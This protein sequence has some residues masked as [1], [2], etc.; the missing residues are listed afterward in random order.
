MRKDITDI[1]PVIKVP[2][3]FFLFLAI[4]LTTSLSYITV[5]YQKEQDLKKI[6][7]SIDSL[8]QGKQEVSDYKL[9]N[10]V[11]HLDKI[12]IE[13]DYLNLSTLKVVAG[14]KVLAT[15]PGYRDNYTD[16]IDFNSKLQNFLF[17]YNLE[18]YFADP[19][20][21]FEIL[22]LKKVAEDFVVERIYSLSMAFKVKEYNIIPEKDYGW[23]NK[24]EAYTVPTRRGTP[25]QAY[26]EALDYLVKDIKNYSY[27][28]GSY[29]KINLFNLIATDYYKIDIAYANK[30]KPLWNVNSDHYVANEKWVVWTSSSEIN[31]ELEEK[32]NVLRNRWILYA[33]ISSLAVLI[34]YLIIKF[35]GRFSISLKR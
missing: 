19:E 13:G 29:D 22:K 2:I 24:S 15:H 28:E 14:Q 12:K 27:K 26:G 1:K 5:K 8:F 3:E 31:L 20:G 23:G 35:K 16:T 7:S 25:S 4:I 10:S 34:I 33:S 32:P 18:E 21:G 30:G 6:T 11:G 9:D 17:Y